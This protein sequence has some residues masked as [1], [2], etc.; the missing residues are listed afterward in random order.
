MKTNNI[1]SAFGGS[2]DRVELSV[3]FDENLYTDEMYPAPQKASERF[4]QA[5]KMLSANEY[6]CFHLEA[7]RE[8]ELRA[9]AYAA[10]ERAVTTADYDWIFR[11]CATASALVERKDDACTV[12]KKNYVLTLSDIESQSCGE[13]GVSS[14]FRETIVEVIAALRQTASDIRLIVNGHGLGMIII[15]LS[16]AMSLRVQT[17][18]SFAFPNTRVREVSDLDLKIDD[19]ALLPSES[20]M[21]LMTGILNYMINNRPI[22]TA[23][24]D[25]LSDIDLEM[26][27]S[28]IFEEDDT[29]LFDDFEPIFI[30]DMNLSV[31]AYNCLRRAGIH[32]VEELREKTDEE[33]MS[34]R[35]LGRKGYEEVKAKL[36]SIKPKPD[37]PEESGPSNTEMLDSLIGL[38][39]VK[40]QVRKITAFAKMKQ[41]MESTDQRTEPVV[42]NMEFLGNPGTAKTT[43]AR[44]IAGI[45]HEIGLLKSGEIVEVGRA[46]LIA[47]YVGHTADKVRNV[48]YR[49]KGKLLFI[50]EAY[51]LVESRKGDFG[52]E[53][54]NTIVQ[55]MENNRQDT[56]VIFAGYPDE[57]KEFFLRN[58]G[59]RS[60]VPFTINFADYSVEEM[61]SITELEAEKRGFTISAEAKEALTAV[62]QKAEDHT[63]NGNGRFCR[64]LAENAILNY[65]LRVYGTEDS[66]AEKDYTLCPDDFA[67]PDQM[68]SQ[69]EDHV[70]IGFTA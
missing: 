45:L 13:N 58:P 5:A 67:L 70:P 11:E 22:E 56:V 25:E 43:V 50:D 44:I 31:R 64:N 57:M 24:S 12:T 32:T 46:D 20:S 49:A 37:V 33:L 69:H 63:E 7:D 53:A 38:Q 28:L 62:C 21:E 19:S 15:S 14:Q 17:M 18:L 26:D 40:E 36:A 65:A 51:S 55:E 29:E 60:R 6:L 61:V 2:S 59:L 1:I 66:I 30:E 47:K 10:S 54:I 16:E 4:I 35:N 39:N 27:E 68:E 3:T 23:V 34:V 52:D 8:G 41:D 48:F 42:L 9:F